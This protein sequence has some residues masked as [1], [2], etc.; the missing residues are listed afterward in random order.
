MALKSLK[1]SR[2]CP[3]RGCGR[4][5]VV[6]RTT[7][8]SLKIPKEIQEEGWFKAGH[9]YCCQECRVV[10]CDRLSSENGHRYPY[11]I[12]YYGTHGKSENFHEVSPR[13][14]QELVAAKLRG[15]FE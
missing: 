3:H 13:N 8:E 10:W 2:K 12:G 7:P 1:V 5:D 15:P 6:W 9:L 4:A 11:I 14:R